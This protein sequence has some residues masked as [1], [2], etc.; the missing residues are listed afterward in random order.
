M[1][2]VPGLS[3]GKC[4]AKNIGRSAKNKNKKLP[5]STGSTGGT[6]VCDSENIAHK[7]AVP[8]TAIDS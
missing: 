4:K 1:L 2:R 6:M 3:K 7:G 5:P 8:D